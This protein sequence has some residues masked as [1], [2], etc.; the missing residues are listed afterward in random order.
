M[1]KIKV[2]KSQLLIVS[3]VIIMLFYLISLVTNYDFNTIIWYSSIILTVLAIILS[4]ALVSG[5]RQ[6][7]NYHSSPENT[8][9]ALK[10]SQIILII[11]IPFYLVLLLQ[12]LIN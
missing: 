12:Y 9:Q 6:R 8:N 3:I 2:P 7:G 11:A 4:G 10:Y 1:K 5:D